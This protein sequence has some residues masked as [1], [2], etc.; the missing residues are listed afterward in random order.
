[1]S[2]VNLIPP[3]ARR[4]V[5]QEYWIRVVTVW[6]VLGVVAMAI[7]AI[8]KIPLYVL[9]DAQAQVYLDTIAGAS[10][11]TEALNDAKN[12]LNE[13]NQIA[14]KLMPKT[15][16]VPFSTYTDALLQQRSDVID[17]SGIS[18]ARNVDSEPAEI[19][20]RGW[21]ATRQDLA[22]FKTT[23]EAHELFSEVGLPLSNLA[24]DENIIFS[25]KITPATLAHTI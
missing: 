7:V 22:Q 25:V 18:L 23:V 13:A 2:S 5:I 12:E 4:R 16:I 21:A 20:V 11:D 19:T 3:A 17:I 1:M 6:L 8:L 24:Q 9:V 15:E 14:T 10:I